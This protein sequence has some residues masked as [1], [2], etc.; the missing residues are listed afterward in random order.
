MKTVLPSNNQVER[1]EVLKKHHI[2]DSDAQVAFDDIVYLATQ[3]C[4]TPIAIINFIDDRRQWFKAKIG[5]E[6]TEL[7]NDT[8]LCSLCVQKRDVLIIPDTLTDA[9]S[10]NNPIVTNN[11]YVRFYLGVPLILS[12][13]EAIGT[14]CVI[15]QKPRE[16]TTEQIEALRVL[17]RQVVNNLELQHTIGKL[18]YTNNN[19]AQQEE[20]LRKVLNAIP[21]GVWITDKQGK[22]L[23]ANPAT[24]QIWAIKKDNFDL[25]SLNFGFNSP[26][27][28]NPNQFKAWWTDTGKPIQSQE[29][30]PYLAIKTGEITLNE[31]IDIQRF[32]GTRKTILNS[33]I[34]LRN[35]QQEIIGSIIVNQDITE[36]QIF[37]QALWENQRL[38]QQIADA[39]PEII[40]IYDLIADQN[41]YA[42]QKIREILGYNP[43]DIQKLEG[44]T[45]TLVHPED[46]PKLQESYKCLTEAKD[47][48]VVETEY[49][50]QCANGEWCWL[51]SRDVVFSK[52]AEGLPHQILG[53]ATDITKRKQAE[54]EMRE[55][56]TALANAVEGISRLDEQGYYRVVN[57]AYA[58][59]CGYEPEEMLG[60]FWQ[61]TVH[62]EDLPKL[63]IAYQ[64]MFLKGKIEV[65]TRGIRKDGSCFYKH[66]VMVAAYNKEKQFTG[67]H[68][69]MKDIT[70]RKESEQKIR[71]QAALLDIATDAIFVKDIDNTILFWN[72]GAQRLYGWTAAEAI[73]KNAHTF[74]YKNPIDYQEIQQI[75][76]KKGKW[77][78]E[79][80]KVTK[81]GQEIIVESR[82][83]LVYEELGNPKSIL[84]VN[85][86]ITE[87]KQLEAQFLRAQRMESLGTLAS[88]IAHDLNNILAPILMAVQL[89]ELQLKD[90]RSMRLLP[91][92]KNNAKRGAELVKQV[93]SFGRGI[94]GDRTIVQ[95]RHLVSEIRHIAKETFPKFIELYIDLS[96]ELWTVLGDATQL[97][98]VLM[99]LCVN[100]RDAMPEGGILSVCAENI[101]IDENYAK[102]NIDAK[103]GPYIVVT[104]ADTGIGIPPEIIDRIFEPFFTTKE[105]GKGT[106]L[107][108]STVIGI[109][110]SHGGFINVYSELGKGTQ[111]KVYLPAI[112]VTENQPTEAL[113]I[114]RGSGELVLVVDDES[115]IID[116]TKTSLE[117][118]G[119]KVIS[120]SDGQQAI[121]IYKQHKAKTNLVLL[122]MMM[123]NMDGATTI[124]ELRKIN[125]H[126][127]I[128]AM[129]GLTA[130]SVNAETASKQVKGFLS[131]PFTTEELLVAIQGVLNP[132]KATNE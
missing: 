7:S 36:Q 82:W 93:L 79:L 27:T 92:L 57:K 125:P 64:E 99:N 11:P 55:M 6:L 103:V 132:K 13:G 30:A 71:E 58:N 96:A 67:H 117:T 108:L 78:G 102:L 104:I 63:I 66:I 101:W 69:F 28:Q 47:E 60:M 49:R 62:P 34:P 124:N 51:I 24:H 112:E 77:Q 3:I 86:D 91:I 118:H 16:I 116:I 85:T 61:K 12:G 131:K 73:G 128:I 1:L 114:P 87:K 113:Q 54:V 98:Q 89:L 17:S 20:L 52:T 43:A 44:F 115:A 18:N 127:K 56:S 97:H 59:A 21:V 119:Y 15:D 14:L 80:R 107:G 94:Q 83:T 75:L 4:H 130:N 65:E 109:I 37:K 38:F 72:Q 120:A 29:W 39:T 122:D 50:M 48:E 9:R 19:L 123:P 2:S 126:L 53:T 74:L 70:E 25:A 5:I 111:F 22:I 35:E 84:V 40:Y 100:A 26:K 23:Q 33:A 106:G 68:C 41:I 121:A 76:L 105:I 8:G 95:V 31:C 42:N 45:R 10:K 32:D 129:S 46:F 110:K 90:E 81:N 88:G